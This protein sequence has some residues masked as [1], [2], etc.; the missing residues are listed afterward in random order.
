VILV[1]WVE[2]GIDHDHACAPLPTAA[3]LAGSGPALDELL[4]DLLSLNVQQLLQ[5]L[6]LG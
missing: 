2:G 3:P 6:H 1:Q 5:D 4:E